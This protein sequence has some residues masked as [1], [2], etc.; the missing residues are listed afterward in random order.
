TVIDSLDTLAMLGLEQEY[1]QGVS[2]VAEGGF[3]LGK[4]VTISVFETVIRVVGGFLSAYELRGDASLL[5]ASRRLGDKLMAAYA[6][7]TGIPFNQLNLASGEVSNGRSRRAPSALAEYG[8]QQLELCKL[9]Q[10]ARNDTYCRTSLGALDYVHGRNPNLFLLPL[11]VDPRTGRFFGTKISL[12]AMG[13]S[14]YEYLLKLWILRGRRDEALRWRWERA[15]DDVLEHLTE[16]G[17]D[18]LLFLVDLQLRRTRRKMDHLA[19]FVPGMLA[20]GVQSGAVPGAEKQRLY[21]EAAAELTRT[22]W[23]MYARTKSGLPCEYVTWDAER[24]SCSARA[25]L[26]RPEA[27]EA[28]FYMWRVTRE[29]KYRAWGWEIFKAYQ[30]HARVP[31]VG[32]GGIVDV[33]AD[34]IKVDDRQQSFFLAE[35]IKYFWLLFSDDDALDLDAVVLNTEAHPLKI[36]THDADVMPWVPGWDAAQAE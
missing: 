9:S 2:W 31:G 29:W 13:D 23:Q 20:L 7:P 34:D 10:L 5:D 21:L 17:P 19:C 11:S 6:T 25:C 33:M 15:M 3:D 26:Q 4:N 24:I 32:Y 18:G 1:A 16:N 22:C 35:T 30:K 27:L 28:M 36:Q 14:Y 12:G 8:T